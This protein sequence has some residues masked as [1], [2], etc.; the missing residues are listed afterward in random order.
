MR[1]VVVT[2]I[3]MVTP[4]GNGAPH[5]WKRLLNSESGIRT[6]DHFDVS[7]LAAKVAGV[8]PRGTGEGELDL[9]KVASSKDRR[10]MDDFIIYGLGAAMEAV[11]DSGWMPEDEESRERTGVMIGSGIGGL[12]GIAEGAQILKDSGPRRISPFFIPA[13]LIN[14]V[15]GHV[16]IKYGFKGPNHAVVT[17]CATGAHAIGDAARII[18]F[19]DADVMVA[20]G[21][22]SAVC[23]LGLAGFAA[24]KALS[25]SYNDSPTE[26][27]RPWDKGR[28]GFV[29]GE[30]AGIVVLEEYEHAKKRGAKIYGEVI[31]YGM[32]G[33]AYHIT[34]PAEDGNGGFRAMKAALKRAQINLDQVDY[35]NAH[36]TSTP[37]GDE[38][39][40]GAVK[41]LFGDH[42]YKLS[43]S[44]TKS[45]IGHLLGAAGAVEAI[46]SLLAMRDQTLPPT[47]NLSNPSDGCDIDLVP[48]VAKQRSVKIAMSNSFGF[49][50]TNASLIFKAV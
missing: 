40:L 24:A 26:A 29:M 50:G 47:L 14:L 43:M 37:L 48:K 16:S 31:G 44:S 12:P 19:D 17:A 36:G 4:L 30:G 46:Y 41:R 6:I 27:S 32:S 18:Q 33:D 1:R 3:G 38:I 20:G 22:E 49:G 28:D 7:D 2:G 42:A 21:T 35:I 45:A 5:N 39:E 13:A 10:R 9:D 34:A 25:T 23:R 15:S 11:E 8:I